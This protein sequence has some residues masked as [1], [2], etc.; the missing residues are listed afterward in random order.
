MNSYRQL[1]IL[2]LKYGYDIDTWGWV[3]SCAEELFLTD[4]PFYG[5]VLRILSLLERNSK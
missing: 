1:I 2:H 4:E 3:T 5:Q